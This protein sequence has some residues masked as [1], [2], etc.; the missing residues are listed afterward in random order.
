VH[1]VD[2]SEQFT[3]PEEQAWQLNVLIFEYMPE[4]VLQLSTHCVPWRKPTKH[5]KQIVGD[6]HVR[7]LP[8]HFSQAPEMLLA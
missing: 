7:H 3:Q 4:M 6:R 2:E 5:V 8:T 1:L